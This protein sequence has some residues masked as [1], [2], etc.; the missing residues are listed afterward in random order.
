MLAR[1]AA[2][3]VALCAKACLRSCYNDCC[4]GAGT[5]DPAVLLLAHESPG[6]ICS[7]SWFGVNLIS[8]PLME[9]RPLRLS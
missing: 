8:F 5:L 3:A 1:Q 7:V 9:T 2:A 4:V 6:A